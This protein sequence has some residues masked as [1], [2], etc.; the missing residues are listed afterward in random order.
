MATN[1]HGGNGGLNGIARRVGAA[2]VLVLERREYAGPILP[3]QL[4]RS[5]DGGDHGNTELVRVLRFTGGGRVVFMGG[6]GPG[7][8]GRERRYTLEEP[9]F[10]LRYTLHKQVSPS[11]LRTVA[12]ETLGAL[13]AGSVDEEERAEMLADLEREN[14]V[15]SVVEGLTPPETLPVA[16]EEAPPEA[17]GPVLT[18]EVSEPVD[19]PEEPAEP[20]AD[21]DPLEAFLAQGRRTLEALEREEHRVAEDRELARIELQELDEKLIQV[22]AKRLRIARAIEAAIRTLEPADEPAPLPEPEPAAPEPSTEVVPVSPETRAMFERAIIEEPKP[23]R[24]RPEQRPPYTAWLREQLARWP[25]DRQLTSETLLDAF[26]ARF[27]QWSDRT[28]ARDRMTIMLVEQ[29]GPRAKGPKLR[30]V[31]RGAYV[32]VRETAPEPTPAPE[33]VDEA[34]AGPL[35][36]GGPDFLPADLV[37]P[38]PEDEGATNARNDPAPEPVAEPVN[39]RQWVM[40]KFGEQKLWTVRALVDE[41]VK[42]NGG[43]REAARTNIS[44]AISERMKG[45]I[46]YGPQLI[47]VSLGLYEAAD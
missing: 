21:V 20:E 28:A 30:R 16:H 11:Y 10:R 37:E 7:R 34:D 9:A 26:V 46:K 32:V 42:A 33:P 17:D 35:S 8:R 5:R 1:A 13:V 18:V 45:E 15:S 43:E 24:V 41:W 4:W 36:G 29:S 6:S 39:Q 31:D 19:V 40:G 27:P 22:Q 47:R 25:A 12:A 3:D 2:A 14:R 23:R 44:K 38:D